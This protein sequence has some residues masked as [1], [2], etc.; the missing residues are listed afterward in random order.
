MI[1]KYILNRLR[2]YAIYGAAFV[3]VFLLF[4]FLESV[5]PEIYYSEYGGILL[6]TVTALVIGGTYVIRKLQTSPS[7]AVRRA[8][9]AWKETDG[10]KSTRQVMPLSSE[11]IKGLNK[12]RI[13]AVIGIG[14]FG[15]LL[16][17][18]CLYFYWR[19]QDQTAMIAGIVLA[20]IFAILIPLYY[21]LLGR[22]LKDNPE[23]MVLRGV[24]TNKFTRI[25]KYMRRN[26]TVAPKDY[27]LVIDELEVKVPAPLFM[28]YEVGD[29]VEFHLVTRWGNK[30]LRHE[31]LFSK[32]DLVNNQLEQA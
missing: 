11:E 31:L 32:E 20:V 12:F 28:H 6:F 21:R 10:F 19:D 24:I 13:L 27:F 2:A 9:K 4:V 26:R 29:G 5:F 22:H 18:G 16:S 8:V 25:R 23:K 7:A 15:G 1:L 17:A 14:I 30:V 3:V